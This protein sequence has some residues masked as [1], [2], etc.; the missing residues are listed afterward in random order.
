[1]LN[2]LCKRKQ[3]Y[4]CAICPHRVST[5]LNNITT[6]QWAHIE[7]SNSVRKIKSPH[8]LT[9]PLHLA[10]SPFNRSLG[11]S[12]R[13][14]I[15][16]TNQITHLSNHPSPPTNHQHRHTR[17]NSNCQLSERLN[18][19]R[20]IDIRFISALVIKHLIGIVFKTIFCASVPAVREI[21]INLLVFC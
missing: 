17:N 21:P 15:R 20:I 2:I 18:K 11:S 19:T 8:S 1:M 16:S 4:E 12:N 5:S 7:H 3:C 14:H 13:S 10:S 6:Q 9:H